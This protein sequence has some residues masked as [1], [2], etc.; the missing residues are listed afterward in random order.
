MNKISFFRR[1]IIE[2]VNKYK[3]I[4]K[5]YNNYEIIGDHIVVCE[6]KNNIKTY[7]KIY[8]YKIEPL[9]LLDDN[10]DVINKIINNFECFLRQM[11]IN[12]QIFIKNKKLDI[13]NYINDIFESEEKLNSAT[14]KKKYFDYFKELIGKNK[15]YILHY[16]FIIVINKEDDIN[17]IEDSFNLL[18]GIDCNVK[19]LSEKDIN[20]LLYESINK[21]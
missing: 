2:K 16:Y 9:I 19:K 7:R 10:I 4:K 8:I 13:N 5:L 11:S 20:D 3:D 18:K 14:L 12:F 15:L 6:E 1:D 21:I 17:N